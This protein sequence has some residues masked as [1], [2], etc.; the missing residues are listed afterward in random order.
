MTASLSSGQE[1]FWFLDR[2]VPG[3]SLYNCHF[4]LRLS[5]PV[6][7][8]VLE[9]SL[10]ALVA[11]HDILRTTFPAVEGEPRAVV[12][13]EC[14]VE[15][16]C[17]NLC[18]LD[19]DTRE[20]ERQR[21]ALTQRTAPFDLARGPLWRAML[22]TIAPAEHILLITQH[23][24]I[25]DA[26]SA[27]VFMADLSRLYKAI[28]DAARPALP[29]PPLQYA[30]YARSQRASL[31]ADAMHESLGWWK[32]QLA[33]LPHLELPTSR[34]ATA[35]PTYA[36]DTRCFTL[37]PELSAGFRA[38][39]QREGCTLF[40]TFLAAWA[41]LLH[42]YSH[43]VDFAIGT[44]SSGREV[45]ELQDV[46]GF[47]V[48]TLVLR[49]DLSGSPHFVSVLHRVR[50]TVHAAIEHKLVPFDEVVKATGAVR[51]RSLN[52][53][54]Q[55]S[56]TKGI[57]SVP[58]IEIAGLSWSMLLDR[59]DGGVDG[60]AKFDLSLSIMEQGG[61]FAGTLEYSTELFEPRMIERMAEHLL[62][63]L[64]AVVQRP[65]AAIAT[66]PLSSEGER[67]QLL[68]EWNATSRPYRHAA[69]IH[70]LF[71]EQAAKTPDAPAVA[72]GQA[73]LTYR[74]LDV[75][76]NQLAHHLQGLGVGP[77]VLV[78]VLSDRSV[79][80]VV[81]LLG[82]L[83][84]GGAYVPLDPSYPKERLAFMLQDAKVSVLLAQARHLDGLPKH[85]AQVVC[86]SSELPNS[87]PTWTDA[88]RAAVTA[89]SL[90]YVVYTSGSMGGPKGV[91]VPHRGVV[92]L[93]DNTDYLQV[94]PD[95]RVMHA[96]NTSF[97]AATFEIWGA[98][99][100]G[101]C[102][103]I[104]AAETML[105]PESFR[106]WLRQEGITA[107]FITT[108]LFNEFARTV[109]EAFKELRH[110]AFGGEVADPRWV[111]EILSHC[112][113][114]R[115]LHV[116]GPTESTTFSTWSLVRQMA[117]SAVGVPIG[118]PIANSQAYVLDEA[119]QPVAVGVAGEL[120][121]GGDGLAR[122]YL[123]RPQLTAE[124]FVP[125]PFSAQPE[126][127]LYRTGDLVR[128]NALGELEFL[129]RLDQQVK[130]RGYRV[131]PVEIESELGRHPAVRACV[132]VAREDKL[133]DKRLVAYVVPEGRK[134]QVSEL[135][136]LLRSR[137]P[138]YMVPSSFVLLA[139]L[140]L[141]PNGKVDR[142]GLP[143]P[144]DRPEQ[145]Q[146]YSGPRDWLEA[147]MVELW[148]RVFE[149][150]P[151]G[152]H[153]DFFALGGHSLLAVR[154]ISAIQ[155]KF[156]RPV[157]LTALF[158]NR[159][160]A[161]LTDALR[162]SAPEASI[163]PVVAL[164]QA[165]S[166]LPIFC[167][168]PSGG[169]VLCYEPLTR[170]LGPDQ[171]IYGLEAYFGDSEASVGP[172]VEEMAEHYLTALRQVQ[173]DGPYQLVG[174]SFGGL[175]AFEMAR[176]LLDQGC[177]VRLLALLDTS[178]ATAESSLEPNRFLTEVARS[179]GLPGSPED[180]RAPG[181]MDGLARLASELHISAGLERE[182]ARRVVNMAF[183]CLRAAHRYV[184][185]LYGGPLALLR[186][187]EAAEGGPRPAEEAFDWG[188]WCQ[189]PVRLYR[190]PG[191][192]YSMT[193][194]PHVQELARVLRGL[195]AERA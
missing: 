120:Y 68:V 87:T 102:L 93:V 43:Q 88:P 128:W 104:A 97:D 100:N 164:R 26:G 91:A 63:L 107:L 25:T 103:K 114:V 131:E 67:R 53:L 55:V 144:K 150:R 94:R 167:V 77:E 185:G 117:P 192:H 172:T 143:V 113:G 194:F 158:Q 152:I 187:A 165:G 30:D 12:A 124:R 149:L 81:G 62:T 4:G 134:L 181:G 186:A 133:G 20:R 161:T 75:S 76:S 2:L 121:T 79:E 169:S 36:G 188:R 71:M 40:V 15:L 66:L 10:V 191:D 163:F 72:A 105:A 7:R 17:I 59:S 86:L 173:P 162:K 44:V 145:E 31:H 33:G 140:P 24:I 106:G 54:I 16:P 78:G 6:D 136:E 180:P 110:L 96:S 195:L 153:D 109:P 60:T 125:H 154:L 132:V 92:R 49:C 168:H 65:D 50:A 1:R 148:E 142:K 98:L 176:R 47:F 99:L 155:D 32:R 108:A 174:W 182:S 115:L 190:V 11:R 5:G 135:R 146:E 84:A 118:R 129:G 22:L 184:P 193:R 175:V 8:E 171:P 58:D 61:A 151:I 157:R 48:N 28:A 179:H 23:H 89:S 38:L 141:T 126:A 119:R 13:P 189:R 127:R 35:A 74:E 130:I 45:P 170:A 27:V 122:G 178:F 139:E 177:A 159:T 83:K 41:V 82:I 112:P 183:T 101:A 51:G 116:Y 85:T 34:T 46:L 147:A 56:F 166:L 37:S 73:Q 70:E 160:V 39:A 90:A 29:A 52:P 57:R 42:R 69:C 137:L 138:D 21:L 19:P 95:D 14:A 156:A 9:Q 111:G 64:Q 18:E 80:M 3:S 123:N